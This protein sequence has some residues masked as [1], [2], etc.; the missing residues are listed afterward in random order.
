[1]ESAWRRVATGHP[2]PSPSSSAASW[3]TRP[4]NRDH[5]SALRK[6]GFEG[7]PTRADGQCTWRAA[8]FAMEYSKTG[9]PPGAECTDAEAIKLQQETMEY[10]IRA[11]K[12]DPKVRRMPR[13]PRLN[14]K[15][16]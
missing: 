6:Q 2:G 12:A 11:G 5:A 3:L 7:V 16:K 10:A 14:K 13:S 1:M 4:I 8:V 9:K 15:K